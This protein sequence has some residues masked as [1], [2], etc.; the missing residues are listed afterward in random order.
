MSSRGCGVVR[1][2]GGEGWVG[3][4]GAGASSL[5]MATRLRYVRVIR[6]MP[7]RWVA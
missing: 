5:S 3:G 1:R 2:G 6:E 4:V 7:V